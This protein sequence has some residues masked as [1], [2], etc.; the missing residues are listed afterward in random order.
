V[1]ALFFQLI[2]D[3]FR[4]GVKSTLEIVDGLAGTFQLMSITGAALAFLYVP[5]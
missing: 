2:E 1:N 4:V 3:R 5:R